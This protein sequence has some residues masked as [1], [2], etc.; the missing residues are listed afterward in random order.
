MSAVGNMFNIKKVALFWSL[1]LK[2]VLFFYG[3]GDFVLIS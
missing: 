2:F 3:L 1:V